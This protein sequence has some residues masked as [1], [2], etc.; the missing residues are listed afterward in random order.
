MGTLTGR[1]GRERSRGGGGAAA[2]RHSE[3]CA[4]APRL[5]SLRDGAHLERRTRA[6]RVSRVSGCD[7][8]AGAT[9]RP[10]LRPPLPH[11]LREAVAIL[12]NLPRVIFF[13]KQKKNALQ[14]R[15]RRVPPG[16][17]LH[18]LLRAPLRHHPRLLLLAE[19]PGLRPGLRPPPAA[20]LL[21]LAG[22]RRHGPRHRLRAPEARRRARLG[23]VQAARGHVRDPRAPLQPHA[24]A[25]GVA[26]RSSGTHG[27][28]RA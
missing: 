23:R 26:A 2:A 22:A 25:A 6:T 5:H 11:R 21:P 8:G 9:G 18:R 14:G 27:T 7:P 16:R 4:A 3:T 24:P 12:C 19:Q 10:V 17:R 15:V 28:G 20:A 13:L 1:H